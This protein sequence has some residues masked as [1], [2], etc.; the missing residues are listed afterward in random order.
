MKKVVSLCCTAVMSC[1]FAQRI[2]DN[3]FFSPLVLSTIECSIKPVR[4]PDLTVAVS[5]NFLSVSPP[6][7]YVTTPAQLIRLR[8]FLFRKRFASLGLV[9]PFSWRP[10]S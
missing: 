3:V 7:L 4:H 5:G 2:L 8:L 1:G 6:S 9:W 10:L